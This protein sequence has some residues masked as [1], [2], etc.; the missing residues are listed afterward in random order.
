M[1]CPNCQSTEAIEV[2]I[3]VKD[4]KEIWTCDRCPTVPVERNFPMIGRSTPEPV[5]TDTGVKR[6]ADWVK[7]QQDDIGNKRQ[8]VYFGSQND[9]ALAGQRRNMVIERLTRGQRV[10]SDDG[11]KVVTEQGLNDSQG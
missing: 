5:I 4:G 1:D 3:R 8:V 11:F 7:R 6:P 9:S 2:R 10:V